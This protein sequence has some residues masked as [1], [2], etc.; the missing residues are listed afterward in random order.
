MTAT[1]DVPPTRFFSRTIELLIARHPSF[2]RQERELFT[3]FANG[4]VDQFHGRIPVDRVGETRAVR[5]GTAGA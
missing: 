1:T 2:L 3:I 4:L 5:Q